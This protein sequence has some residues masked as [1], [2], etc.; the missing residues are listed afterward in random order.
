M[1]KPNIEQYEQWCKGTLT[2]KDMPA[3]AYKRMVARFNSAGW[4]KRNFDAVMADPEGVIAKAKLARRE[5]YRARLENDPELRERYRLATKKW[6]SR[7]PEYVRSYNQ[8]RQQR[9]QQLEACARN[10]KCGAF[11]NTGDQASA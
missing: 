1:V 2:S 7:N 8:R 10:C 11:S 9:R 6:Q 5:R 4:T 3:D